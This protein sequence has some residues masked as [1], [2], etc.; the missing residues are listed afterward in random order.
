MFLDGFLW[1]QTKRG[2][3]ESSFEKHFEYN[4][5]YKSSQANVLLLI[6]ILRNISM[7]YLHKADLGRRSARDC[8]NP[9]AQLSAL[10][11]LDMVTISIPTSVP[12]LKDNGPSQDSETSVLCLWMV[13]V[14]SQFSA[15]GKGA[16]QI[17]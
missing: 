1:L 11:I 7:S 8:P 3:A 16:S 5:Q 13:L 2:G 4:V 10:I 12:P 14:M 15:L 9:K 6:L 17:R